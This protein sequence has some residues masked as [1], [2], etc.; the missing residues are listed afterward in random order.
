MK[1]LKLFV[2]KTEL[3]FYEENNKNKKPEVKSR[4]STYA[5]RTYLII[6]KVVCDFDFEFI[7]LQISVIFSTFERIL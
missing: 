4:V 1:V 7:G 3:L 2:I 6:Q 5:D